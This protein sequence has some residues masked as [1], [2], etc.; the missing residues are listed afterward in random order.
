MENSAALKILIADDERDILEIMAKKILEAGYQVTTA[1]DGEEAL[2]KIKSEDPDVILLDLNMPKLDGFGVLKRIRE[3]PPSPKWQPV[4]IISAR[5][6]LD[7]MKKGFSLEADHYIPKPCNITDVLKG[8][9]LM[10]NLIPQ[11]KLSE[12]G[13]KDR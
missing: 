9:K 1:Q 8:I 4:I 5:T 3:S 11:R 2:A 10:I 12:E 6:D 13:E 7:D